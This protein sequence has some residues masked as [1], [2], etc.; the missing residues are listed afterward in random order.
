[1]LFSHISKEAIGGFFCLKKRTQ[2]I[3]SIFFAA[4][5]LLELFIG[6]NGEPG[7]SGSTNPVS[8]YSGSYLYRLHKINPQYSIPDMAG[9]SAKPFA[10]L[11]PS[12]RCN[13]YDSNLLFQEQCNFYSAPGG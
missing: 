7:K 12:N 10:A 13:I 4:I 6:R 8:P 2:I 5:K 11:L 1:M 9:M 3:E